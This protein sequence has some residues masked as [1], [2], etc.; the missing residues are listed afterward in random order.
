[1]RIR[2][3]SR[4]KNLRTRLQGW[5]KGFTEDAY[6]EHGAWPKVARKFRVAGTRLRR[7]FQRNLRQIDLG[8]IE[9]KTITEHSSAIRWVLILVGVYLGA[10]VASQIIGLFIRPTYM[11][12]P[13]RVVTAPPFTRISEDYEAVL[14]RNMFNVEGEIPNPFDQGLLDCLSQAK[15]STQRLTLL[16]TIV[17]NEDRFS[18]ALLQEEGNVTKIAVRKDDFFFDRYVALKVDRKKLCFQVRSTQELEYIEIPEEN[19]GLL[20]GTSLS[21]SGSSGGISVLSET[22]REISRQTLDAKLANLNEVLQT[23]KAVPHTDPVTGKR[24]FLIQSIDVGSIFAELGFQRGDFM[25]RVNEIE[26]DNPG[27]GLE[28]FQKLRSANRVAIE[29]TRNGQNMT[30]N[31]SVR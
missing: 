12:L 30:L 16:G 18:V 6:K 13:K 9:L 5:V 11:P 17:M 23:A 3:T 21:S 14:K 27:K 31:Y 19:L 26:L 24:G 22:E 29:I 8:K 25:S 1:M 7:R 20:G 15:L 4:F 10:E 28:A 2:L